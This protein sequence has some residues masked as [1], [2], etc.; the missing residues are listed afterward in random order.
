MDKVDLIQIVAALYAALPGVS[1]YQVPAEMPEMHVLPTVVLHDL[2]CG[3]PCRIRAIYHPDFGLMIDESLN[4]S[5]Y[6]YDRSIVFH[7][8]V[9]HAQE[10]TGKFNELHTPCERRAAAEQEAYQLQNRYLAANGYSQPVPV[11]NWFRLCQKQELRDTQLLSF[12]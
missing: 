7:E 10:R 4:I 6:L 11:I 5:G 1:D 2:V 9:H 3:G 12:E 8:L